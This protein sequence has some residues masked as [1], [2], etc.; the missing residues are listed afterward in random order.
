MK[1]KDSLFTLIFQEKEHLQKSFSLSRYHTV[2]ASV[3]LQ[4]EVDAFR[5]QCPVILTEQ[6]VQVSSGGVFP[7]AGPPVT[8]HGKRPLHMERMV[9]LYLLQLPRGDVQS[10]SAS[11]PP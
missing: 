8:Q 3:F 2:K 11:L 4:Q 5:W 1:C 9:F 7:L 6:V 10:Q